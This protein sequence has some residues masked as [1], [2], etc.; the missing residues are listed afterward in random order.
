VDSKKY[1][2]GW[3]IVD[4]K[5]RQIAYHGGYVSGYKSELA[6]CPEE[7]IGIVFLTNSPN[8]VASKSIPVFL[9]SFFSQ[10]DKEKMIA[11]AKNDF[12]L[13]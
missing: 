8:S 4:Y 6:I 12:S 5:G 11:E 1:A 3:R 2:I 10:K 7:N 13:K 9:N